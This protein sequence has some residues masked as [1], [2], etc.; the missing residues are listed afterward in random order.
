[1]N[2]SKNQMNSSKTRRNS[3][4]KSVDGH[5]TK[6]AL[7]KKVNMNVVND[8]FLGKFT[9]LKFL[10]FPMRRMK[11]SSKLYLSIGVT[12]ILILM[13][14][15]SFFFSSRIIVKERLSLVEISDTKTAIF[16]L[17][18]LLHDYLLNRRERVLEQWGKRYA[19][20]LMLVENFPDNDL[21][22]KKYI[23]LGDLFEKEVD[24]YNQLSELNFVRENLVSENQ[25]FP[26]KSES[27]RIGQL[28]ILSQ[29][30]V[31]LVKS[32]EKSS[33]AKLVQVEKRNRNLTFILLFILLTVSTLVSMKIAHEISLSITLIN[34]ANQDIISGKIKK[35]RN[36]QSIY[37]N[38]SPEFVELFKSRE[39]MLDT[40][41]GEK[42]L[43]LENRRLK[44]VIDTFGSASGTIDKNGKF[45]NTNLKLG[46]LF[47]R[48][49]SELD[50]QK[51]SGFV[52]QPVLL[53]SAIKRAFNGEILNREINLQTQFGQKNLLIQFV[54]TNDKS[55]VDMIIRDLTAER[56]ALSERLV[57][58]ETIQKR[59]R[60]SELNKSK[61]Q[62]FRV[63]SHELKTPLTPMRMETEMLLEDKTIQFGHRE[64]LENIL[65][66]ISSLENLI[67]N[68]IE[69][70]KIQTEGINLYTEKINLESFLQ[71]IISVF[72]VKAAR[73]NL[74]L[75][76]ESGK[77]PDVVWD[78]HRIERLINNLIHNAIKFT[79][80]GSITVK[81]VKEGNFIAIYVID[82]GRG[83]SSKNQKDIFKPFYQV[84]NS[85]TRDKGGQGLGLSIC[86]GIVR[87]HGG[88][89][90]VKSALGKG[91]TF[92]AVLPLNVKQMGVGGLK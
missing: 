17:N 56:Q 9:F 80:E 92:K 79:I 33:R 91:S 49:I 43:D 26:K 35:I 63:T 58:Q 74:V 28:I 8:S 88:K 76:F 77:L 75:K 87:A 66:S 82:T 62:I 86:E 5:Q 12:F 59:E 42:K 3:S 20:G 41:I 44:S 39:V 30:I 71:K 40:L 47:G 45:V 54:P 22:L 2:S 15:G 10:S 27:R 48:K 21:I 7:N 61:M 19:S 78:K 36:N 83:I 31:S 73:K 65:H 68:V 46:R 55:L 50:G 85:D 16:D 57:L 53:N 11:T 90:T 70:A 84:D 81:V 6:N 60:E 67:N 13:V 24:E 72:I 18:I 14:L 89:I 23:L 4:K 37:Q 52:L 1:M 32:I 25:L 29:E 64:G 38:L 69:I 51:F 34:Q